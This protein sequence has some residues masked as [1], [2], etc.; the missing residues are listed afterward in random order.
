[1]HKDLVKAYHEH[2]LKVKK[3]L[4]E[5]QVLHDLMD[6]FF[7][8]DNYLINDQST[9]HVNGISKFLDMDVYMI[10]TRKRVVRVAR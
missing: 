1:M 3:N 8:K 5:R 4:A 2:G 7:N 10:I 9:L 6:S